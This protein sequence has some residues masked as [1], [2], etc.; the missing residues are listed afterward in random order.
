MRLFVMIAVLLALQ[1]MA[2]AEWNVAGYIGSAHTQSSDL[3]ITQ[4]AAATDLRLRGVSWS[5]ESFQS[6]LYYGVRGGDFFTRHLGLEIEFIH[7]K[8]FAQTRDLLAAQ[9]TLGGTAVNGRVPMNTIVQRFGISHG[10]NLLLGNVA[11]RQDYF[12]TGD[13]S[14]GCL[15]VSGRVGIGGTIPHAEST[16][17]GAS[18]EHYQGGSPVEQVAAGAEFRLIRHLYAMGEYKFT[19]NHQHVDVVGGTA[20]TPLNSHHLVVGAAVH[21]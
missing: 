14:L 12:R 20:S 4:P 9:G 15:I 2:F 6:P 5:G 13:E 17:L 1:R 11:L 10:N 18:D 8:V 7:L 21:F 19:H 16:V 3:R